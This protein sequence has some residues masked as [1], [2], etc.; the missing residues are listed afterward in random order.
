MITEMHK[1]EA[2]GLGKAPYQFVGM[3]IEHYQ[4]YPGAPLQVGGSC[5]YC[6]QGIVNTFWFKSADGKKFKVGCDCFYKSNAKTKLYCQVEKAER[7][8][9]RNAKADRDQSVIAQAKAKFEADPAMFTDKP[10]PAYPSKTLRDYVQWMMLNAGTSGKLKVS[11][12][13]NKGS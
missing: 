11:K 1:F 12:L 9:K 6:G 4:A 7:E 2:A 5:D 3:T 10:H 13:I 8:F